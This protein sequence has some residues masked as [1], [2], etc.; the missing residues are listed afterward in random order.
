MESPKEINVVVDLDYT[1]ILQKKN[2]YKKLLL[3]ITKKYFY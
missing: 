1:K 2:I 3:I